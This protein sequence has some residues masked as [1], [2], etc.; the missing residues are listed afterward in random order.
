MSRRSFVPDFDEKQGFGGQA[1]NYIPPFK[2]GS[3][4]LQV[5]N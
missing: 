5:L 4:G 1:T 2:T 3:F